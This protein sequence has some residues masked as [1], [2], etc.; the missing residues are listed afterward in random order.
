MTLDEDE[1][2]PLV[3]SKPAL[4]VGK[5]DIEAIQHLLNGYRL[6]VPSPKL[7]AFFEYLR[8]YRETIE[9]PSTKSWAS[10]LLEQARNDVE[11]IL[12]LQEIWEDFL[13]D[14]TKYDVEA[15]P[16][17]TMKEIEKEAI[18]IALIENNGNRKNTAKSLEI[19]EKTL[20]TK[21]KLY[22]LK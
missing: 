13:R 1:I 14:P 5:Q 16:P 22:G 19:G 9:G 8:N 21:I 10:F 4:F 3:T 7:K 6:A 12:T 11:A 18:K 15:H 17:K 2:I 20:Y